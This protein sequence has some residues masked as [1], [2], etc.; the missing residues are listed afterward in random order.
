MAFNYTLS[1]NRLI[2]D[3]S[4]NKLR[5]VKIFSFIQSIFNAL[6]FVY[7][8][9]LNY[10]TQTNYDVNISC[11]TIVFQKYLQMKFSNDSIQIVNASFTF[12]QAYLNR[13]NEIG[14]AIHNNYLPRHNEY[15]ASTSGDVNNYLYLQRKSEAILSF[16]FIVKIPLSVL[17]FVTSDQII[18]EIEAYKKIGTLYEIQ[19]I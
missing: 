1:H 4:P 16:D 14:N 5:K 12:Y 18:A 10:R 9:F 13:K 3:N 19:Y 6:V 11:Q 15:P 7:N 17:S 8:N 2:F